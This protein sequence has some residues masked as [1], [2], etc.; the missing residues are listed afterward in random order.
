MGAQR[1]QLG[2]AGTKPKYLGTTAAERRQS[3]HEQWFQDKSTI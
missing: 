3:Q 2:G 1:F